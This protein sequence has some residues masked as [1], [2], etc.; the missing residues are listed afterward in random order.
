MFFEHTSGEWGE[1]RWRGVKN[2][3]KLEISTFAALAGFLAILRADAFHLEPDQRREKQR[4]VI[5]T[6]AARQ[7]VQARAP[8]TMGGFILPDDEGHGEK[9]DVERGTDADLVSD[10]GSD[11]LDM[12]VPVFNNWRR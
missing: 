3:Y 4:R 10:M 2:G 8:R 9:E 12:A 6:F 7:T 5:G 11:R 1:H